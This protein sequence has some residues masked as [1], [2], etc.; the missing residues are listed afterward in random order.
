MLCFSGPHQPS[1]MYVERGSNGTLYV[2]HE[3][4]ANDVVLVS[5]P[6]AIDLSLVNVSEHCF[7]KQ[8]VSHIF[9]LVRKYF[10]TTFHFMDSYYVF[11]VW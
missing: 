5:R 10:C 6:N 9:L 4:T 7:C 2:Y 11:T 1:R 8:I 3:Q